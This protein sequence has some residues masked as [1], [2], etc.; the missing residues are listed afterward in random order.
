MIEFTYDEYYDVI[1]SLVSKGYTFASFRETSP[2][3]VA[4]LR[5]DVDFSPRK[6]VKLAEIEAELGVTATYF[7]LLTS[8][9]YNPFDRETRRVI[10]EVESHGHDIGLHFDTSIYWEDEP[11]EEEIVKR[12]REEMN[13]LSS[14]PCDVVNMVAFHNPPEWV[15]GKNYNGFTSTY[16]KRFFDDIEYI[17]DSNHRWKNNPPF[18]EGTP[19][20]IQL[21]THPVL[22]DEEE[23]TKNQ[24]LRKEREQIYDTIDEHIKRWYLDDPP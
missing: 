22:W 14:L 6:A 1:N 8:S 19:E 9:L 21:L 3:P 15:F 2:N 20:K 10:E 18:T 24:L 17:S 7:F 4:Y 12:V 5:H 16:E 23:M 11:Q 13:A